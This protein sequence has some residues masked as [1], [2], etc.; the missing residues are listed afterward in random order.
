MQ[1]LPAAPDDASTA[2]PGPSDDCAG[3]HWGPVGRGD[4]ADLSTL[5]TAI[6]LVDE[7]SERHSLDELVEAFTAAESGAAHG[8]TLGRDAG[9]TAVAV[10]WNQPT[11]SDIDPRRVYLTGGVHPEWRSRGIGR[12]LLAWQ[13]R[14]ARSWYTRTLTAQMG[15]LRLIVYPDEK[16][17]AQRHLYER[18]GLEAVRWYADMVLHFVAAGVGAGGEGVPVHE[19]P[20]GIR[21]VPFSHKHSDSVRRAHNEAFADHWGSQP[22]DLERWDEQLHRTAARPQWS[23]VAFDAATSEVAGY[24][25]SSVYEQDWAAQGFS[26]GWT[27]RIGVRQRWRG[28]GVAKALLTASMRSFAD[29]GLSAAGLGVDSDNPSGAFQLYEGLGYVATDTKVMYARTEPADD[30]G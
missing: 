6:E 22:V 17:V 13:M 2:G 27:D 25:M 7:P 14:D 29:A 21:I 12:S 23:W 11:E 4:L 19:A 15:P 5:L 24:A 20:A 9:G 18:A 30:L 10:G 28:R 26:D 3:L 16:L 1:D 8:S